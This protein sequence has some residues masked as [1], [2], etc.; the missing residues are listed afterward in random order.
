MKP[1][2]YNTLT[3]AEKKRVDAV[4]KIAVDAVITNVNEFLYKTKKSGGKVYYPNNYIYRFAIEDD[5]RVKRVFKTKSKTILGYCSYDD[6][7]IVL[8]LK[9]VLYSDVDAIVDTILHE[10]AHAVAYHLFLHTGH[11]KEF[12]R[13]SRWFGSTPRATAKAADKISEESRNNSKY[14]VVSIN[15]ETKEVKV[16]DYYCNRKLKGLWDRS[17]KNEPETRGKLWHVP[18]SVYN[19][20]GAD[21]T[22][23]KKV[24]FR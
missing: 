8:N 14:R 12:R 21:Y 18:T 20:V 17:M 22:E 11:G 19:K 1:A 6:K 16:Y 10:C 5:I 3:V 2:S 24:A 4:Y 23:L 13:V 7:K 15:D 9:H